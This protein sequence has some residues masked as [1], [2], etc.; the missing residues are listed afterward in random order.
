MIAGK[1][2]GEYAENLYY[3]GQLD[4]PTWPM[5]AVFAFGIAV[6]LLRLCVTFVRSLRIAATGRI[7]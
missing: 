4:I 7:D 6:L 2:P 5:K 1:V 3:D